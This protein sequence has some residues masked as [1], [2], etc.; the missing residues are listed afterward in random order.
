MASW[1]M[2]SSPERTVRVR[3]LDGDI[4]LC[5]RARHFGPYSHSASLHPGKLR[6]DEPLGSYAGFISNFFSFSFPRFNF[7][8]IFL[9][10]FILRAVNSRRVPL[11]IQEPDPPLN[12]DP[13]LYIHDT[14]S[15]APHTR[16]LFNEVT[17]PD[18]N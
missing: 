1:L 9:L 17:Q 2:R 12:I 7:L 4:A 6:P 8:T 10:F 3:A 14:R 16:N 18:A 15:G 5:S 13:Q 11:F